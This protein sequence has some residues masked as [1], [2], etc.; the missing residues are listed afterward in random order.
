[1]SSVPPT[2]GRA[3]AMHPPDPGIRRAGT[4]Q[5]ADPLSQ[6]HLPCAADINETARDLQARSLRRRFA[7]GYYLA[8]TVAQLAWGCCRDDYPV[9]DRRRLHGFPSGN[10]DCVDRSK[11]SPAGA[12][13]RSEYP[14]I[15]PLPARGRGGALCLLWLIVPQ[16][17]DPS[18][19]RAT[20]GS[21]RSATT[22][23]LPGGRSLP[24]GSLWMRRS[25][26]PITA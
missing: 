20:H 24:G 5:S 3:R 6:I 16:G 10:A 4:R 25:R 23:I 14:P 17:C 11:A 15:A 21:S 1:M 26:R 9:R 19:C 8:A 12:G 18:S 2:L 7:I 13:P 22:C